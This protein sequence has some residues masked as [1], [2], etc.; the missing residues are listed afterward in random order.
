MVSS[1]T[2]SADPARALPVVRGE[3]ALAVIIV[4][5]SLGV[6]LMLRSGSGISAISSVPYAF[7]LVLPFFTLGTWTYLFQGALILSLMILRKKLVI[8]YLFSFVV[9]FFFGKMLDLHQLWTDQLPG[10]PAPAGA[11]LR[12]ELFPHLLW[13]R[14]VQ[15]VQDAHHPH[16]PV[17]PGAGLHHRLALCP[18]QGVLRF[19]LPGHHRRYDLGLPGP[20]GRPWHRHGAGRRHHGKAIAWIGGWMDRYVTFTSILDPA[21]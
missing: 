12:P 20:S 14:P 11:L 4:I 3:A 15:P 2:L 13:H 21:K 9:G 10:E 17:P 19:D 16:R 1:Q 7:S 18:D 6:L 5:N 8:P